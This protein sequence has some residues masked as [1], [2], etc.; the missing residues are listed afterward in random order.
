MTEN[1]IAKI[2]VDC[3][4][5]IHTSLGPG[6]LKSVYETILCKELEK[7]G[8]NFE[9]QKGIDVFYEGLKMERGF[10]ADIIVG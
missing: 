3:C 6:L 9:R 10:R 2:I 5:K 4:F 8:L 1:E 7:R